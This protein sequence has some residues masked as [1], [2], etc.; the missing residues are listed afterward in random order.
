MIQRDIDKLMSF[1]D[2]ASELEAQSVLDVGMYLK[3]TGC[4]SRMAL[5]RRLDEKVHLTG[6]DILPELQLP[7]WE[8]AY[9]RIIDSESFL[10]S[11]ED[12]CYDVAFLFGAPGVGQ[13]M[14]WK[15]LTVKL[16]KCARIVV[17][18]WTLADWESMFDGKS[19]YSNDKQYFLFQAKGWENGH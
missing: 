3:R 11:D 4:V 8:Q 1:F 19:L 16:S 2:V 17:A 7:V 10:N 5:G 14:P 13:R 9:D 15:E 6:V 18:D 12:I